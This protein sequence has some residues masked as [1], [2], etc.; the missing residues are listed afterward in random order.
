M[1]TGADT[2]TTCQHLQAELAELRML[3]QAAGH[4]LTT[5][6]Q[7]RFDGDTAP[8]MNPS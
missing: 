5:M 2:C 3:L 7:R 1:T 8:D 6:S 4:M